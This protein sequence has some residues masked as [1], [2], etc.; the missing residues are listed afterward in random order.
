MTTDDVKRITDTSGLDWSAVDPTILGTL[1]ERGLDPS[2][3]SQLGAHFTSKEDIELLVDAVVMRPLR[4][5][6]VEVRQTVD[7]LLSTGKKKPGPTT[8]KPLAPPEL[9]KAKRA[10]ESIVHQFL[11]RL[12]NIKV[13]DPACGSGNF[14]YVTLQKLKDLEK[15]VILFSTDTGL[16]SFLP[17]VGPWQLRGIE[18]NLYAFDLAQ[19][20]VWIGWLQ[21]IRSNGFGVPPEPILRPLDRNFQCIDAILDLSNPE[22]PVEPEWPKVD[23]IVGNPALQAALAGGEAHAHPGAQGTGS[24]DRLS[25]QRQHSRRGARGL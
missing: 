12:Q 25:L 21:W 6:W 10:A 15:E 1:F 22:N 16:G 5:E 7:N 11:V 17:L 20:T 8:T 19:M 13:L 24:R 9:R 4:Q 3:R 23:F 14:L 2:K 18:I